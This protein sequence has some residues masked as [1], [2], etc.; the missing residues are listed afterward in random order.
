MG[1]IRSVTNPIFSLN[2]PDPPIIRRTLQIAR[3]SS[4]ALG[5]SR[6][7]LLD[8]GQVRHLDTLAEGC[9]RRV[10]G[11]GIGSVGGGVLAQEVEVFV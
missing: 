5:V 10:W 3:M 6:K 7:R 1:A 9:R 4:V 8:R 11:R 2:N